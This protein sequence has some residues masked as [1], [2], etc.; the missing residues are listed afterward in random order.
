MK[1]FLKQHALLVIYFFMLAL[2]CVGLIYGFGA[3]HLPKVLVYA[4]SFF[5]AYFLFHYLFRNKRFFSRSVMPR[6]LPSKKTADLTLFF[7]VIG[8]IIFHLGF[9]GHVPFITAVKTL[10]YYRIAFIRQEIIMHDSTIIKYMSAFMIKGIIP[11]ALLYFYI[12]NKRLFW[13]FIPFAIF[14]AISLMQKSLIVCVVIPICVY[15]FIN[16][17]YLIGLVFGFISIVGVFVLVY[18]TNPSLRATQGEIAKAMRE[19][20]RDYEISSGENGSASEHFLLATDAIYT[21]V[22]VTTG[23]V[24]GHWFDHIPSKYPFAKGCGYRFLAPL[25]GCNFDDYDYSRIIY[26]YVYEK[27]AKIGL[28]GTVTVASFVYDYANFGYIGLIYSGI[29]LAF[30]FLVLNKLFEDNVKWNISLNTLFIF[31]LTSGALSTLMLSGGWLVTLLLFFVYRPYVK[32]PGQQ[33]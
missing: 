2:V 4:V 27:E 1:T 13:F 31:W 25:L 33:A 23:L 15:A 8:F 17:R 32:M 29:I 30:F 7:G 18:A 6:F 21:R 10:D 19:T 9:L 16:R 11:F 14:Y 20:G 3:K 28:K 12:G 26:D 22:F 5:A 24:A